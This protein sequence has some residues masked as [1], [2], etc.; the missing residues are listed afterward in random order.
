MTHIVVAPHP[1]DEWIG[2]GCTILKARSKGEKVKILIVTEIPRTTPRVEKSK[3]LAK[4]HGVKVSVLGEEEQGIAA[5]RLAKFLLKEV[6]KGD[7]IYVPDYDTHPDHQIVHKTCV[8]T[9]REYNLV[10]YAVY[11]NSLNLFVRGYHR[12]LE[13]F[14]GRGYP[15]FRRHRIQKRNKFSLSVKNHHIQVYTEKPRDADVLRKI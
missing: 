11:N 15:S 14:T 1:D 9:L 13:L 3:R 4:E 7:V 8:E 2:C 6:S 10:S 5:G 12:L